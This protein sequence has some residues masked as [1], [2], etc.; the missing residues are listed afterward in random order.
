MPDVQRKAS[1]RS[2]GVYLVADP[3][4]DYEESLT[5]LG[6]YSSLAAAKYAVRY[7]RRYTYYRL[8]LRSSDGFWYGGGP[9]DTE[10]QR[11]AGDQMLEVWTFHKREHDEPGRWV[12]ED[13]R[14]KGRAA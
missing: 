4:Q 14:T 3:V 12:H 5:I 2:G 9:R 7:H 8:M 11:W 10:I 13:L 6:V 1:L